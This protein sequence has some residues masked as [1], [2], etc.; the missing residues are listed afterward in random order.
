MTTTALV[1]S[2]PAPAAV[3][4]PLPAESSTA[5]GE[6]IAALAAQ[7]HA[8]TYELLVL[9][10]QFDAT[11]GWHGEF[12]TSAHWL[13][14]R[15][16]ISLG[17]AREKL[18]V[19]RALADLPLV[20]AVM[21]RGAISYAKVRALTRV[22]RPDTEASLLDFAQSAS[23]AQV[24]RFVGAW[25]RVDRATAAPS[26]ALR[27]EQRE[28]STWVDDDG[29]LVVRARLA[30][31]EG[32]VVQRA[33]QAA[34]DRLWEEQRAGPKDECVADEI[35]PSQR[36]ADAL[37]L[38]AEAALA[39]DLTRGTTADRYQVILRVGHEAVAAGEGGAAAVEM[40]QGLV[41]VSAETSRR[42]CCDA[43][44]VPMRVGE[45]G[46]VLDIGRKSR[47]VPPTI[48]RALQAR[49]QHCQFPGCTSRICDAHHVEH[50]IDG[51]I[52]S[53]EN[54][55]LLCR[56]HHRLVHEGGYG[57]TRCDGGTITVWRPDGAVLE[58]AP[59][60]P[61]ASHLEWETDRIPVGDGGPFE[62]GYAVEVL[63]V[64]PAGC[65]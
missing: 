24:E 2:A 61:T 31:E 36:R 40:D 43:A 29:M 35:T 7:L 30:P 22:A 18:R 62:L 1:P 59:P 57:L 60:M 11:T 39:S 44:V 25:R 26:L 32:A 23:A 20:S 9:L 51:G 50:W 41:D 5:L 13:H 19:A 21:A 15:T 45:G 38:P 17:A 37:A 16:G 6:R 46:A 12:A 47:S 48:R 58:P 52:T 64:P 55:V 4:M 63:Y 56:R 3:P 27:H 10:R 14:W 34:V 42:L 49:D 28:L 54:L 33:L 65:F 53:L 8:A